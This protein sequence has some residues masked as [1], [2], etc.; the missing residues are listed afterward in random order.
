MQFFCGE[1][2]F[3]DKLP[4]DRSSMTHWWRRIGPAK[5]ELRLLTET[6][7]PANG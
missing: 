5:L 1:Q 2:Y 7:R 3:R 4:L 6:L